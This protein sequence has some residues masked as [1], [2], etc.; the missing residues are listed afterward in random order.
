MSDSTMI[1]TSNATSTAIIQP[2]PPWRTEANATLDILLNK[3]NCGITNGKPR[4]AIS[5]ALCCARAA[6]AARKVKTRLRLTPPS[7]L[8]PMKV[9]RH[10]ASD[11][12]SIS[13]NNPRLSRLISSISSALNNNF[14][15]MKF[16]APVIE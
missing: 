2:N 5:A 14:D 7:Q 13:T 16:A 6:I 12:P 15:R 1:I 3:N 8:I 11:H 9:Q 10:P 4:I